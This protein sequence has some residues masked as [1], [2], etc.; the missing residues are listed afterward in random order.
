M[1]V[2]IQRESRLAPGHGPGVDHAGLMMVMVFVVAVAAAVPPAV[3]ATTQRVMVPA[4]AVGGAFVHIHPASMAWR[5]AW[6]ARIAVPAV[7][8]V[9]KHPHAGQA[10]PVTRAKRVACM[11]IVAMPLALDHQRDHTRRLA[12]E[13]NV[14]R[15]GA[16]IR[17]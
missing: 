8:A 1:D 4:V 15:L 3:A 5:N 14:Q 11:M 2:C 7:A 10:A 13:G 16:G 6:L 17:Q 12:I 9:V